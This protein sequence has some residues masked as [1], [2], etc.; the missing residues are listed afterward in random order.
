[1]ADVE[2]INDLSRSLQITVNEALN[3]LV[4]E[5]PIEALTSLADLQSSYQIALQVT[6]SRGS[7]TLFDFLR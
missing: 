3:Q 6:A 1:Q 7:S 2:R 5:D 4:G